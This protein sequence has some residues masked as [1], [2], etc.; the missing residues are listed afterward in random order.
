VAVISPSLQA[1]SGKLNRS[2]AG[3][4]VAHRPRAG[5]GTGAKP[6]GQRPGAP[7]VRGRLG[8]FRRPDGRERRWQQGVE[9]A[10]TDFLGV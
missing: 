5:L 9:W 6:P 4:C 10:R 7:A 8:R 2:T 3:S 1:R